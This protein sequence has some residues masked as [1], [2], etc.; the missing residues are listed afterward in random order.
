MELRT[1]AGRGRGG[2]AKC[3]QKWTRE[4]KGARTIFLRKSFTVG[5]LS[6]LLVVAMAVIIAVVA[7]NV[8]KKT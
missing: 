8:S 1:S 5:P 4:R 6:S 7:C 2:Y 3:E